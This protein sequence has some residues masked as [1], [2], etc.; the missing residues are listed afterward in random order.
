[1]GGDDLISLKNIAFAYPGSKKKN[2]EAIDLSVKRGECVVI[3]GQSGCG[4]TTLTRVLNGLGTK[5]Y[6]GK[7]T[8]EYQLNKRDVA[9]LKLDEIAL[10]LGSVF[11][12]PRSQ[13]FA[14]TVRDEIVLAM[15]NHCFSRQEM[16]KRLTAVTHLLDLKDLLKKEMVYLS[17]GEKQKVAIASVYALGPE[18]LVLDEPSANLDMATT[19]QLGNILGA[20]KSEGHTI[21]VSEHRIHYLNDILDRL[22]I[23][24][25]GRIHRQYSRKEALS[26]SPQKLEAMGLRLFDPPSLKTFGRVHDK[27]V[28]FLKADNIS[29]RTKEKQILSSVKLAVQ[30]KDIT[31]ITGSNGS[32]KST[33]CKILSGIQKESSGGVFLEGII[34]KPKKRIRNT[35]LVQQDVDYQ[36]YT[37]S[38]EEEIAL[39]AKK[40]KLPEEEVNHLIE[41]LG[42]S[43][44]L[45]KH[46][47]TLSGGQKQRVLLLAAIL[48]D[49]DT[50][51]LD[52]PTSGL[53]GYHMRV[54]TDILKDFA[55]RGKT[56][57]II[58][59]D[60][61]FIDLV[62]TNLLY[63][64][65]GK[66]QYH[67]RLVP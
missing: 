27:K 42:L 51:I 26:L 3:T 36:L 30:P 38:V 52:E 11:Q 63:I 41:I 59:H 21:I 24:K 46:P 23:M 39:G 7:L 44:T 55:N 31:V 16:E 4:K 25:E 45:K 66:V 40:N 9:S 14:K 28:P 53:D 54:T 18:G 43:K 47:N 50:I 6:E 49:V 67:S 12:D 2:I 64:Q 17:S 22:I 56:I 37:P 29:Y 58:T 13:F 65:E 33:L 62:A 10:T 32:G 5:F 15:E 57:I 20:L 8:G 19:I 60:T 48:G 61:E 34:A 35:F 1:M